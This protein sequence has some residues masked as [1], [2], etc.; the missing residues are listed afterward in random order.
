MEF[1]KLLKKG[2]KLNKIKLRGSISKRVEILW[3]FVY[4]NQKYENRI[5]HIKKLK[6]QSGKL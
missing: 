2:A 6:R 4:F 1:S 3:V 5:N